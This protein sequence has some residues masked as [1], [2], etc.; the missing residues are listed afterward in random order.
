MS[1]STL[2]QLADSA[3]AS[4]IVVRVLPSVFTRR[5]ALRKN[6]LIRAAEFARSYGIVPYLV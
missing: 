6:R 5:A 1:K 3:V 2:R 4:G